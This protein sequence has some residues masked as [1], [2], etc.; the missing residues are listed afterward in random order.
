ML[1]PGSAP[2]FWPSARTALPTKLPVLDIAVLGA[3]A[4]SQAFARAFT[5]SLG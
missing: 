5:Q 2:A 3:F 1:P 4:S